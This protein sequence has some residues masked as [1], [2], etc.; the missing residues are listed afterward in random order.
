VSGLWLALVCVIDLRAFAQSVQVYALYRIPLTRPI[1]PRG[2]TSFVRISGERYDR[3]ARFPLDLN[4]S[5]LIRRTLTGDEE[6]F[7]DLVTRHW[8]AISA[9]LYMMIGRAGGD[10]EQF[11]ADTFTKAHS[12][13]KMFDQSRALRPWLFG[14][15]RNM[16][17]DWL[18]EQRAP[19]LR[20]RSD[21]AR[22][23][24]Q[25]GEQKKLAREAFRRS[26]SWLDKYVD[27]HRARKVYQG[28]M[29]RLLGREYLPIAEELGYKSAEVARQM[30]R[31]GIK[32]AAL[33]S[34]DALEEACA[35]QAQYRQVVAL[36]GLV[37]LFL[38]V[39][40]VERFCH[41][42]KAAHG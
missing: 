2:R 19:L 10:Y 4:D 21:T 26:V 13:L 32:S 8:T 6:A 17:L 42:R 31:N 20:E 36:K 18:K 29:A 11:T 5:E 24:S 12:H 28:A 23:E 34:A 38:N 16:A 30:I 35:I 27:Q 40:D 3:Q 33:S 37:C 22:L 1:R 39:I 7:A 25:V 41:E 15:A 14:I 9:F